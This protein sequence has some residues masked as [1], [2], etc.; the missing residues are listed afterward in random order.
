MNTQ[1]P[2]PGHVRRR[3]GSP[4]TGR[5]LVAL[6]VAGL[7]AFTG[8]SNAALADDTRGGDDLSSQA[9]ELSGVPA[10]EDQESGGSEAGDG[11][12]LPDAEPPTVAEEAPEEPHVD[13]PEDG[14]GVSEDQ[15]SMGHSGPEVASAPQEAP[16]EG[17]VG[18]QSALVLAAGGPNGGAAPF[19]Y[20]RVQDESGA[21]IPGATFKFEYSSPGVFGVASWSTEWN[22]GGIQDCEDSCLATLG[23][24]SL[25]RDPDGGDFLLEHRGTNRNE[26]NRLVNGQNYRV[27]QVSA[28]PGYAWV[29][30][31]DNTKTVGATNSTKGTWNNQAG[32]GTHDFG[33]FTVRKLETAPR[34]D[35]G[36]VYGITDNGQIRQAADGAVT[37]LGQPARQGGDFNGL[38]IGAGGTTVYA[39][40][41]N[42]TGNSASKVSIY[43]YDTQAGT[44]KDTGVDVDS[45]QGSGRD[46]T[47]VAGAVDL[48]TGKYLL[49]GYRTSGNTRT[50]HIWQ[51][52]PTTKSV[53][54]KGY[55]NAGSSAGQANGDMAF[56]A[57]GD[58]FVVRGSGT[59][60]T[61]LSVTAQDLAAATG[62]LI[63]SSAANPVAD[64][65]ED[66]N[67]V[68]FDSNGKGFLGAANDAESYDM[69]GWTNK[70]TVTSDLEGSNDLASCGLPPS[71]VIEKEIVGGRVNSGDQFKLTLA[72]GNT[73]LGTATTSGSGVGVQDQRVGPLPTVR[74]VSLTFS[75]SAVGTTDLSKYAS[76]YQCTVTDLDGTVH[77]LEQQAGTNGS[78]TIPAS[79]DSVRCVF[80]NSPLVANVSI[81]KDVTDEQGAN[82]APRQ[83]WQ[84]GMT[85][86]AA[87]GTVSAA[88]TSPT[89]TTNAQ[90]NASWALNFG[91]VAHRA[92][93]DVSEVQ[94]AG[95]E[96]LNGTCR[97]TS[98]S[99]G[100]QDVTLTGAAS[101]SLTG[102][103]PGD[104]VACTYT[105]KPSTAKLTLVKKVDNTWGGSSVVA[106]W[107]LTATGPT[108]GRTISGK[109]G[110][111]AITGALVPPGSY[112]LSESPT[113]AGY[114]AGDW[115]CTAG[116][117]VTDSSVTLVADT[118]V[119]CTVTNSS[120]PGSVTWQKSDENGELLGG[121]VWTLTGPDG[122]DPTSLEVKDC[123]AD[124]AV[125]CTDA[126][127]KD[128]AGGSFL[129]EGL[130]WGDYTLVETKAPAGYVLDPTPHP[131][132][133]SGE[134]L[135]ATVNDDKPIVNVPV[136]PP[137][138]PLTGGLGTDTFLLA[139]GGLLA[140]AGVGGFI[141][142]RRSLRLRN[143]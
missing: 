123:V 47:F 35:A 81:H 59:T 92:T 85:A 15:T 66:V 114:Q 48:H 133:I 60:T 33:V 52:D 39:Y 143:V 104:K 100:T 27:S 62:G 126:D 41:R 56:N 22:A 95:F 9:V 115:T 19:V 77:T 79:G 138:L 31:G 23:G 3:T 12:V 7:L 132:F 99:G 25:D 44:W 136:V 91:A 34:C 11:S 142:R 26:N 116:A 6:A 124:Q 139:G 73:V 94:Q 2:G 127:D 51:Y 113:V 125:D 108:G 28:P 63:N 67:G 128:P 18:A 90:G 72:Q 10:A 14:M 130:K 105:N 74:N 13:L 46:V 137:T 38:G 42:G 21:S 68:A 49:G 140:L 131:F 98:L 76:V 37:N 86:M 57:A 58:L 134:K 4:S 55:I 1:L 5:T 29:V 89:Q 65:T 82:P 43:T 20:W 135:V 97:V 78:I 30:P 75:E 111:T 96:F 129:V 93:V 50:F 103:A 118:D 117:T 40:D 102:I 112:T 64:T 120:Q 45:T 88:P 121:S 101:Q 87:T 84:V 80:R 54:Y 119:T 110:D 16:W 122:T 71:I 83:G 69:P 61:I 17:V 8:F 107:T 109:T 70:S 141:H 36:V 53:T 32:P 106:D 24:N